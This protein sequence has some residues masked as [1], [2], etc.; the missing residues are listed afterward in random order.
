[1][2]NFSDHFSSHAMEYSHYRPLYPIE[3]ID[4]LAELS[5]SKKLAWDCGCGNGQLATLLTKHFTKIIATDASFAQIKNAIALPPIEYLCASAEKS[6]LQTNSVDLIVVAQAAHWF[7]L[8][9][10]YAEVQRVAKPNAIIALISYNLL[11][12]NETLD[13]VIVDF[14]QNTLGKYWPPE[15]KYVENN[16]ADL[17]FPFPR[18][19]SPQFLMQAIWSLEEVLHYIKTWS[20]I[21]AIEKDLG[22][23]S[24]E[25]LEQQLR[26][27]GGN[28]EMKYQI[29]WPLTILVGKINPT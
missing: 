12:I 20:A 21:R 16:Y 1:M 7:D 5:P 23:C 17:F 14:Y 24:L 25:N 22:T 26:E 6:P 19:P 13:K 29:H 27:T 9:S 8:P 4:Y 15:R 11:K 3:L 18:L 2:S 10:F 28:S